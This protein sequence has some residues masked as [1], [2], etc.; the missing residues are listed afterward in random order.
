MV[1]S[2]LKQSASEWPFPSDHISDMILRYD[3]YW[4]WYINIRIISIYRVQVSDILPTSG[5]TIHNCQQRGHF[6]FVFWGTATT[7][8]QTIW[9]STLVTKRRFNF[10]LSKLDSNSASSSSYFFDQSGLQCWF[11][12]VIPARP[13]FF[14][15]GMEWDPSGVAL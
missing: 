7:Q 2:R 8:C 9:L 1:K 15:T 4:I 10:F 6:L 13:I 12:R 3:I 11:T 5:S 14:S